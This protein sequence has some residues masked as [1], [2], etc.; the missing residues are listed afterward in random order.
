MGSLPW[1]TFI[2]ILDGIFVIVGFEP[3]GLSIYN[4]LAKLTKESQEK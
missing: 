2:F 1:K 4:K 3:L